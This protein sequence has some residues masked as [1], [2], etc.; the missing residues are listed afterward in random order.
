M[1][2]TC[3]QTD[4]YTVTQIDTGTHLFRKATQKK[5]KNMRRSVVERPELHMDGIAI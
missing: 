3:M 2:H 5:M 4:R 1:Y